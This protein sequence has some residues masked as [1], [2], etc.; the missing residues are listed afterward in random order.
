MES[1]CRQLA[2]A[3]VQYV[4][5]GSCAVVL[6]CG[7]GKED[8]SYWRIREVSFH[9]SSSHPIITWNVLNLQ[10]QYK[11]EAGSPAF[12]HPATCLRN[13]YSHLRSHFQQ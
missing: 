2:V 8:R 11:T 9:G 13:L 3:L 6:P 5:E 4:C 12:H 7:G 10:L 1:E